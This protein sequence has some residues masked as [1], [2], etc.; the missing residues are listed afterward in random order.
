MSC[1][2][3]P[4][5]DLTG[6]SL[7]QS[8]QWRSVLLILHD[9]CRSLLTWSRLQKRKEECLWMRFAKAQGKAMFPLTCPGTASSNAAWGS[10]WSLA[11]TPPSLSSFH[12]VQWGCI[13]SVFGGK[14]WG[15]LCPALHGGTLGSLFQT[16]VG[17]LP[18][19]VSTG[20]SGLTG[21]LAPS[22]V[23]IAGL[24]DGLE[25]LEGSLLQLRWDSNFGLFVTRPTSTDLPMQL[26]S[27]FKDQQVCPKD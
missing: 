26:V 11:T 14:R 9:W 17:I 24:G 3:Q 8:P 12:M 6:N 18:E 5:A 22:Q 2:M 13:S 19:A 10:L 4:A 21:C 1:C 25:P 7:P 23:P 16:D 20:C 27:P 15:S